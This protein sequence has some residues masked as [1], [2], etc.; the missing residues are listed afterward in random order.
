MS[1][2]RYSKYYRTNCKTNTNPNPEPNPKPHAHVAN[3]WLTDDNYRQWTIHW[4]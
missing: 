1:T 2:R 4:Q 3:E